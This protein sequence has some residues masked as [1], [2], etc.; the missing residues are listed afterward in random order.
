M[1]YPILYFK[2]VWALQVDEQYTVR[3]RESS[4]YASKQRRMRASLES[5]VMDK[6]ENI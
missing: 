2:I 5:R 3:V 1:S 6:I 4:G